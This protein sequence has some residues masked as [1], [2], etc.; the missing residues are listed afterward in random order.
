MACRG[1]LSRVDHTRVRRWPVSGFLEGL[2]K[3][4]RESVLAAGRLRR[5]PAHSVVTR[6]GES[7]DHLFMLAEGSARFFYITPEGKKHIILWL[8]PGQI[9][10][11]RSLLFARSRNLASA[12]TVT[13][14]LFVGWSRHTMRKLAARYPR[15]LDN[16]ILISCDFHAI[17]LDSFV[18][19]TYNARQRLLQVLTKLAPRIGREIPH[20]IE[21]NVT[22]EDLAN[23]ARITAFT[24]SRLLSELQREGALKKKRGKVLLPTAYKNRPDGD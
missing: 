6:Q 10:G 3:D 12:E 24:A 16:A 17:E 4:Q 19:T 9:L 5:F 1:S 20:G 21:L 23:A 2:D 11:G 15:L 18:S 13:E 22:N 7:A 8:T 14:S